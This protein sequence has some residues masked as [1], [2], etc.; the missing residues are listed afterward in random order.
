MVVVVFRCFTFP[1]LFSCRSF[2]P[3]AKQAA[4]PHDFSVVIS[5]DLF[6][7][8]VITAGP[9]VH[10]FPLYL[11]LL[12]NFL[13]LFR[14][15]FSRIP[16]CLCFIRIPLLPLAASRAGITIAQQQPQQ[17]FS[18]VVV[19]VTS[20]LTVVSKCAMIIF[21]QHQTWRLFGRRSLAFGK[22]C[23]EICVRSSSSKLP[24]LSLLTIRSCFVLVVSAI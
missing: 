2:S 9:P 14:T 16:F 17:R 23:N 1:S 19:V 8:G 22:Q 12:K 24:L 13:V 5:S 20:L 15:L 10:P 7:T 18:I 11:L 21:L 4:K 6:F 3:Q